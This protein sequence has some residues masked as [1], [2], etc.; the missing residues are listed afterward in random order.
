[1]GKETKTIKVSKYQNTNSWL[2]EL[3]DYNS[4]TLQNS[5]ITEVRQFKIPLT[6]LVTDN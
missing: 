4:N 2:L 5:T 3:Y 1:V 6:A